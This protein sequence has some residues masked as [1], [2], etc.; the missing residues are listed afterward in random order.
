MTILRS[1][2]TPPQLAKQWGV[3]ADKIT[4]FVKSGELKAIDVS[5]NRE[6]VRPRYL[7]DRADI[8]AFEASRAVVPPAPKTKRRRKRDTTVK[9]FF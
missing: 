8:E 1:K 4:G 7:I 6:S 2:L 9:E 3:S 5:T